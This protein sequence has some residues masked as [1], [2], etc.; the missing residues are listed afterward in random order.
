MLK[1]QDLHIGLCLLAQ[2][3]LW[4]TKDFLSPNWLMLTRTHLPR[5]FLL[6]YC[7]Y[8]PNYNHKKQL[9]A[10]ALNCYMAVVYH[11][12]PVSACA[13]RYQSCSG[14]FCHS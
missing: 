8:E 13:W 7:Q 11:L 9:L 2:T 14:S 1:A 12:S 10:F 5:T 3:T 4:N 6:A